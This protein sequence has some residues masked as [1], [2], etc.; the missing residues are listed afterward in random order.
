MATKIR[1]KRMGK[2]FYAVYRVVVMD[3]RTKRDGRAIEEIGLYNPNTQPSTIEIKSDR[4]QYWLGVG[5]QPTDQVLNLL[6]ITGDWQK[7]KGLKGAE[8]T[9]K[10]AAAKPEAA[11]LV[12]EA[13]NKAQKLKAAKAEAA[14]KAAEAETPAEVQHDDEKVELADVEESAPESV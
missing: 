13:E 10:T 3:S 11:V 12:E 4:A 9:L 8:G 1:L 2:K 7:F 14:A 6:K 5:A